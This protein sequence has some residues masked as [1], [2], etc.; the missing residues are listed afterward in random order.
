MT[1]D[2]PRAVKGGNSITRDQLRSLVERIEKLE[3]K[4]ETLADDIKDVYA[5]AKGNGYDT[6][7]LRLMIRRRKMDKDERAELDALLGL[8]E[9]VFS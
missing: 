9:D 7:V 5:E 3:E 6:K 1:D 8:Y 4:K 2:N